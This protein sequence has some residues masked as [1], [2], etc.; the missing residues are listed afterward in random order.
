MALLGRPT[1]ELR[2]QKAWMLVQFANNYQALGN[3]VK[4]RE[5]AIAAQ[6]LLT[7]LSQRDPDNVFYLRDLAIADSTLGDALFQQALTIRDHLAKVDR[8]NLDWQRDLALAH[9]R[10]GLALAQQGKIAEGLAEL[11]EAQ[12]QI[13]EL[14]E[15]SSANA[16]FVKDL[17]W[18]DNIVVPL[19]EAV[20][21]RAGQ[22]R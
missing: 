4:W 18:F 16:A 14:K 5:R 3:T 7:E 6:Q 21:G 19:Q 17:A 9:G 13:T 2:Y 10:V 1:D 8:K 22:E 20:A 11:R 15:Q 12:A